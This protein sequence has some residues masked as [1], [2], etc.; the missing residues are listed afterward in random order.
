MSAENDTE[1]SA[2]MVM[3]E[4]L[5]VAAA[6]PTRVTLSQV[7]STGQKSGSMVNSVIEK[8]MLVPVNLFGDVSP[9]SFEV[10]VNVSGHGSLS[11]M[12][13]D[14]VTVLTPALARTVGG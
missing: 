8:S 7:Y 9:W 14:A 2:L 5:T 4:Q 10:S 12:M 1:P 3:S 13:L 11:V 6:P